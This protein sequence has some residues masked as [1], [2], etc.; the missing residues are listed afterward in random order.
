MGMTRGHRVPKIL[1]GRKKKHGYVHGDPISLTD[2]DTVSIAPAYQLLA[3]GT[4]EASVT[5]SRTGNA[6][7]KGTVRYTTTSGTTGFITWPVGDNADRVLVLSVTAETVDS[8]TFTVTLSEPENLVIGQGVATIALDPLA[9]TSEPYPIHGIEQV[10]VSLAVQG[11]ELERAFWNFTLEEGLSVTGDVMAFD[12]TQVFFPINLFYQ[13]DGQAEADFHEGL[14]VTGDVVAFD[15]ETVF[16]PVSLF[17]QQSGQPDTDYYE[18]L[19]VVGDIAA[20]D[21]TQVFFPV[22]LTFQQSGQTDADY[23]EGLSVVG[24]VTSFSLEVAP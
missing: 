11:I 10:S 23:Y 2:F 13:L 18:G 19:S 21:L 1:K 9:L 12:L 22:D 5:L 4:A 24:D 20:F 17:Y 8:G 3:A 6:Y 14:S 16:T 7:L 15:L